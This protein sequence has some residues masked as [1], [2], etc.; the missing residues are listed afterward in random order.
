MQIECDLL[1]R[2]EVRLH[3]R[4]VSASSIL[5]SFRLDVNEDM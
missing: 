5:G 1:T 2:P 4:D 3:V